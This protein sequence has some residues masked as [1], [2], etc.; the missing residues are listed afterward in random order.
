MY[1]FLFA[2]LL[3]P[4]LINAQN[5]ADS[6]FIRGLYTR[7]LVQGDAYNWLKQLT[8]LTTENGNR[9]SGSPGAT[10][11]VEWGAEVLKDNR[12]TVSLQSVI[13]PH[14]VRGGKEE[15]FLYTFD[16][17]SKKKKKIPL[18]ITALGN[19][20]GTQGKTLK[21]RIIEVNTRDEIAKLDS[22][23]VKGSVIFVNHKMRADFISTFEAYSEAVGERISAATVAGKYGA[24]AVIVR[25]MTLA[26][27]DYPHTGTLIYRD[28]A[29]LIPAAAISTIDADVLSYYL[30]LY[31]ESEVTL[32]LSCEMLP[33]VESHN[34]I[35]ELR[36]TTYPDEIITM[37]GHLD[38]WDKGQGAHDDG[39]GIVQSIHALKLL[40]DNGWLPKRTIRVVLFMNEENGNCGGKEYLKQAIIKKEKHLAAIE[41]DAGGFCPVAIGIDAGNDT[42]AN[43]GAHLALLKPYGIDIKNGGGGVDIGPLQI[44]GT[45]TLSLEPSNQR[46]FDYHH[47][48]TDVF[49]AVN[50][51]EL[52]LGAA[53]IAATV[54]I[55]SEY[56]FGK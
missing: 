33:M 42:F 25:S 15:C 9:L 10:K 41:S 2:I 26:Y 51:R 12:Y 24:I 29:R 38:A 19:S 7:A 54:Y 16:E 23:L 35:A 27:D 44:I 11:A 47:A 14:W 50:K 20:I 36:G 22:N 32:S 40:T 13:V 5:K 21:A 28:S 18:T 34:V 8:D 48:D 43:L 31:P 53:T 52:E 56:G 45:V 6:S 30:K 55:L 37:G 46:Y 4:L 49:S 17:K 3:F 39:A 1:K